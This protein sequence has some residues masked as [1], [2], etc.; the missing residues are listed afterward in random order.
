MKLK[1]C[2]L[3]APKIANKRDFMHYISNEKLSLFVKYTVYNH[4]RKRGYNNMFVSL[5][6]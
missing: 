5:T 3:P 1:K 4:Y 2:D 6:Y